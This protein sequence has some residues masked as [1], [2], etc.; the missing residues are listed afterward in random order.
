MLLGSRIR[1][2]ADPRS[3]P[4]ISLLLTGRKVLPPF[5]LRST[6]PSNDATSTTCPVACVIGVGT[7]LRTC[8]PASWLRTVQWLPPSLV[9][10]NPLPC[11]PSLPAL[12]K[13]PVAT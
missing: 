7:I 10:S 11:P 2:V 9:R 1:H 6:P 8:C 4:P 13:E 3:G 5:T 12:L